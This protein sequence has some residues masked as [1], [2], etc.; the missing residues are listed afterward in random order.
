MCANTLATATTT[1]GVTTHYINLVTIHS[2][3]LSTDFS[4]SRHQTAAK[5]NK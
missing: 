5:T 4:P 2:V 1:D 3:V